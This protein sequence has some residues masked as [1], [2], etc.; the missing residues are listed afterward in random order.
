MISTKYNK[1]QESETKSSTY[2]IFKIVSILAIVYCTATLI[3]S[4]PK[5]IFNYK[6]K[7]NSNKVT[8]ILKLLDKNTTKYNATDKINYHKFK[9]F[10]LKELEIIHNN[11][12]ILKFQC[13]INASNDHTFSSRVL[14]DHKDSYSQYISFISLPRLVNPY[15]KTSSD[16]LSFPFFYMSK[17][18]YLNILNIAKTNPDEAISIFEQEHIKKHN[19]FTQS[20]DF[21][22]KMALGSS[23][24]DDVTFAIFFNNKYD[25]KLKLQKIDFKNIN[26]EESFKLQ[27]SSALNFMHTKISNDNTNERIFATEQIT[28]SYLSLINFYKTDTPIEVYNNYIYEPKIIEKLISPKGTE[29]AITSSLLMHYSYKN[30]FISYNKNIE[31]YLKK[32]NK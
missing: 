16:S 12:S 4:V 26:V 22:F 13:M 27:L 29:F 20:N 32:D 5:N 25:A 17:Y 1:M 6:Y 11:C 3:F 14:E 28:L 23:M 7:E 10:N 9:S 8:T 2:N 18:S 21:V 30:Y 15:E 31:K 19:I 24:I